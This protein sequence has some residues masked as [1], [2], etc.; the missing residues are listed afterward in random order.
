[1]KVIWNFVR[2]SFINPYPILDETRLVLRKLLLRELKNKDILVDI[3][4]ST[5]YLE[6]YV[7]RADAKYVGIDYPNWSFNYERSLTKIDN[8]TP[9]LWSDIRKIGLRKE[10]ADIVT[11]IDV[12]EHID[13]PMLAIE[14]MAA[15]CKVNGLIVTLIPFF[16]EIHGGKAGEDDYYRF[17]KS[18][19][20]YI[21]RSNSCEV[22]HSDYIGKFGTTLNTL[23]SG[24]LIREFQFSQ[25]ILKKSIYLMLSAL[26]IL[27]SLAVRKLIDKMDT[28]HRNPAYLLVIAR[29]TQI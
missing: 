9:D 1:M 28:T 15:S 3:G 24:F 13:D 16:M 2:E 4:S 21:F 18:S 8:I 12:L 14:N 26:F 19:M 11:C 22:V 5:R 27:M 23:I 6:K 17:T 10:I 20:E 7:I 25:S 29:K